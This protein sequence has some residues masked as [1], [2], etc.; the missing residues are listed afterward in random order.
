[1]TA[2]F[3]LFR[4]RWFWSAAGAA[5]VLY[6]MRRRRRSPVEA[7]RYTPE[8]LAVDDVI[9]VGK[10]AIDSAMS[11]GRA[12]VDTTARALARR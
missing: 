1:M 4:G 8:R 9:R 11:A 6:L 12:I 2:M 7:L 10:T 5:A 3:R